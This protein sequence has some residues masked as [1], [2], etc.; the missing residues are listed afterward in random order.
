MLLSRYL[1]PL[2]R[3]F[4][5]LMIRRPPRSTLFPYTTLF[6]SPVARLRRGPV[7][8]TIGGATETTRNHGHDQFHPPWEHGRAGGHAGP[9]AF[10]LPAHAPV[11]RAGLA[12]RSRLPGRDAGRVG[13]RPVAAQAHSQKPERAEGGPRVVP[14]RRPGGEHRARPEGARHHVPPGP[15]ADAQHHAHR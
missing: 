9:P 12:A 11:R 3:S 15:A 8:E 13:E 7:P 4:F 5:F 1:T 10:P 2:S 6:R 14:A